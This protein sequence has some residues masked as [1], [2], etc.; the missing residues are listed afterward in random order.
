MN[1]D[2]RVKITWGNMQTETVRAWSYE[3]A[4]EVKDTALFYGAL[5][6]EII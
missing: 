5:F 3:Q 1:E 4:R 6:V 2:I